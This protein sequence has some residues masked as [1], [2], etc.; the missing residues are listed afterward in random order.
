MKRIL[1]MAM[2]F[3]LAVSQA[4]SYSTETLKRI[5]DISGSMQAAGAVV[6]GV[7]KNGASDEMLYIG[8][9]SRE[10]N[11]LMSYA[12]MDFGFMPRVARVIDRINQEASWQ[13]AYE[14]DGQFFKE[15]TLALTHGIAN[16]A[17]SYFRGKGVALALQNVSDNRIVARASQAL[18]E[19]FS[20]ALL[21]TIFSRLT[22]LA[23]GEKGTE[24]PKC[25]AVLVSSFAE[26][27]ATELAYHFAGEVILRNATDTKSK[28]LFSDIF[29]SCN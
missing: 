6:A 29:G 26:S 14:I 7:S 28:D 3:A 4:F 25:S 11:S 27:L 23:L 10:V 12:L 24:A 20:T 16:E 17:K 15:F 22:H 19:A 18:G 9:I 8:G 21:E 1:S 2:V 5:A 13:K